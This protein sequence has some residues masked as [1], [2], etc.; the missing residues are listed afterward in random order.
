MPSGMGRIK[1]VGNWREIL[2]VP[3]AFGGIGLVAALYGR[4]RGLPP[5]DVALLFAGVAAPFPVF[6]GAMFVSTFV[7]E[8]GHVVAA[9]AYGLRIL[10]VRI[11]NVR[12]VREGEGDAKSTGGGGVSAEKTLAVDRPWPATIISLAGPAA[13]LALL[14][15]SA[16]AARHVPLPA[17]APLWSLA[18]WSG[19]G[20]YV[21]LVPSAS[22]SRDSDIKHVLDHWSP[23][24]Q[25]FAHHSLRRVWPVL[26]GTDPSTVDPEDVRRAL[27]LKNPKWHP[28]AAQIAAYHALA[29]RSPAAPERGRQ[30][31]ERC[32]EALVIGGTDEEKASF[33]GLIQDALLGTAFAEALVGDADVAVSLES[34]LTFLNRDNWHTA[35]RL[36][37]A[38]AWRRG[39]PGYGEKIKTARAKLED[40]KAAR[41]SPTWD[42]AERF[43]GLVGEG[44]SAFE[45]RS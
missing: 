35:R 17:S 27:T 33:K 30:Y 21:S 34:E 32:R 37:A 9:R 19:R 22:G 16:L 13:E 8:M 25:N 42:T 39:D 14:S 5:G 12:W 26:S 4:A 45:P 43:L 41:P 1:A 36:D 6:F 23:E 28:Y 3:F 20:L 31:I 7:H 38:L 44:T 40:D 24:P 10:Q 29:M 18:F 2:A 11:Y 15:G